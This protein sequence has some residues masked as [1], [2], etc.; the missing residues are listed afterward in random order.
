M[1]LELQAIWNLF[2]AS[3]IDGE[4]SREVYLLQWRDYFTK[5]VVESGGFMVITDSIPVF[6]KSEC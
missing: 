1:W 3:I 2:V 5:E 6:K 4:K